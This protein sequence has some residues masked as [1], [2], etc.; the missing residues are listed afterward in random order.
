M[1]VVLIALT[2]SADLWF[3]PSFELPDLSSVVE[4]TGTHSIVVTK[5]QIYVDEAPIDVGTRSLQSQLDVIPEFAD[6]LEIRLGDV[7]SESTLVVGISKELA[8][9]LLPT[10]LWH[11]QQL[12][13]AKFE[14]LGKREPGKIGAIELRSP[15]SCEPPRYA[16]GAQQL[17]MVRKQMRSWSKPSYCSEPG[18]IVVTT[19]PARV[20]LAAAFA[21]ERPRQEL[22]RGL[23]ALRGAMG[24][25]QEIRWVASRSALT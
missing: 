7:A 13:F 20:Y 4:P 2:L 15:E 17:H 3:D 19:E 22:G 11:A 23:E 9:S 10:V 1:N 18:L 16:R 5:D 6:A 24:Q 12:G 21:D 25:H 14:L 8:A